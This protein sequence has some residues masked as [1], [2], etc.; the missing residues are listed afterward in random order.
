MTTSVHFLGEKNSRCMLSSARTQEI[1]GDNLKD[2]PQLVN[3]FIHTLSLLLFLAF[4][5][6]PHTCSCARRWMTACKK[7]MSHDRN[8]PALLVRSSVV[9]IPRTFIVVSGIGKRKAKLGSWFMDSISEFFTFF[10]SDHR[11]LLCA[12]HNLITKNRCASVFV[13]CA[14]VQR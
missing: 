4:G 9:I 1:W 12:H 5:S 3:G 11:N 7:C 6:L 14:Q 13:N 10:R 8:L 2:E